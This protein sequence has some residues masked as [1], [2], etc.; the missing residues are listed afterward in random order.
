V[1][2]LD[3]FFSTD[4]ISQEEKEIEADYNSFIETATN[5]GDVS[6]LKKD[7]L[8]RFVEMAAISDSTD[9]VEKAELFLT[10][11]TSLLSSFKQ[12]PTEAEKTVIK[13]NYKEFID[14]GTAAIFALPGL[15]DA[16]EVSSLRTLPE[17]R[18]MLQIFQESQIVSKAVIANPAMPYKYVSTEKSLVATKLAH[19]LIVLADILKRYRS[20][21]FKKFQKLQL[22]TVLHIY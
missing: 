1:F 4:A 15:K 14:S 11:L 22:S 19:N 8:N 3:P 5:G 21:K 10:S 20:S 7:L 18:E 2:S 16:S 12:N 6:A 17:N 13:E 9:L